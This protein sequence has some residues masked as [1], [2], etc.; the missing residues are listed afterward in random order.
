MSSE[1]R[2]FTNFAAELEAIPNLQVM[3][4]A[5]VLNLFTAIIHVT[6]TQPGGLGFKPCICACGFAHDSLCIL[7]ELLIVFQK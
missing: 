2:G 6:V 1:L 7:P 3:R 4:G 5:L